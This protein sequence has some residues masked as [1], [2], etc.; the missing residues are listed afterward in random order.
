MVRM[1]TLAVSAAF[2]IA[3]SGN[4]NDPG[5]TTATG[6]VAETQMPESQLQAT[7]IVTRNVG[8]IR[9]DYKKYVLP[10]G[11]T[12]LLHEDRSDPLVHLNVTY[13][14]GS[15]REEPQRS[16]FAHFFEH[17]MFQGSANI[18]DDEHFRIVTESGGT[19]NGST[20]ADRT[21]YFQTV[22][23]NQL[24]TVLWL[25]ADRMG[26]LLEAVTQ[27]KFENQRATVKN[28]RGQNYD[29]RAYGLVYEKTLAALYPSGHPYSW[30]VIGYLD[31]LDSAT[32]DDLK[33]FFLRWYGPNNATLII[34]GDFEEQAALALLDKYFGSIP[35]GP[36]VERVVPEAVTLDNDR[37][38]SYVDRY[39]RFPMLSISFP[40]VPYSHP[41]RTALAALASII[42]NG[43]NSLFYKQFVVNNRAIAASASHSSLELAGSL[44]FDVQPYP[45]A[46]LAEFEQEIRGLLAAFNSDS[47]SDDDLETFKG[48][49]EAAL[50]NALSSVSGKAARLAMYDYLVDNPDYLPVEI[51]AIRRL[52]RDDILRVFNTYVAGKPAVL[53]SVLTQDKPDGLASP[54]NFTPQ[55][56]LAVTDS[57]LDELEPRPVSDVFDRSV[58]P[59]PGPAP[60][61]EV[62]PFWQLTL[63]NGA[64]LIGSQSSEIPSVTLQF[65]F[66]GGHLLNPVDKYGLAALTASMMNEGT[67]Q[68]SAEQYEIALQKLG[69]TLT[70][71]AGR[72]NMVVTLT[73]L[74]R[75]LPATLLLLE[76]RLLASDLNEESLG[77]LRRQQIES[78]QA[79]Q[80]QPNSIANNVYNTLLYG[81]DHAFAVSDEGTVESL[82]SITLA[83][84]QAFSR[85]AFASAALKIVAVGDVDQASLV[86]G[87]SFLDGLKREALSI[88]DVPS[89]APASETTLYLVDKP[90]AAQ[91]EIRI[92]YVTDMPYDATGEYYKGTLMNYVLGA[93]FTSRINLNLREDKGYTYGA[94][95]SFSSTSFAGPFTASS[96]VLKDSTDDSVRQFVNEIVGY[97][98]QGISNQ[99]LDFMRAAITQR[100]ALNYETPA[101]KAGFLS[102]MIKFDLP[103]D[104]TAQQTDIVKN[105]TQTEINSLASEKLP[106]ERMV[107][108]VVGDKE[109]IEAPLRA[110][111]YPMFELDVSGNPITQ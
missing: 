108:L 48:Q 85:D 90:G 109:V 92:G 32:L 64:E 111:G 24:E 102:R 36:A 26:F 69:S 31:D 14:V 60:E 43:K 56:A 89:A 106:F 7:E 95:S 50:I 73:S 8:D 53:M 82:E 51:D 87:L 49:S 93:A 45:G 66:E 35:P 34:A 38:I 80:Q 101:Q 104:V 12:V 100:E 18:G 42:G 79:A 86:S 39:I 81:K 91:S 19:L 96:S 88:V 57:A 107:I 16:G 9:I 55:S 47:I 52:T 33:H 63:A 6:M 97:R 110:L 2:L 23:G 72:E 67:Q 103:A 20:N 65:E 41:D 13:H 30:P 94:R 40:T 10:N 61:L 37:Y 11:L 1:I 28:E 68:L 4:D 5:D 25:E 77:R 27:E 17:M 59:A 22:P 15:A 74:S 54:D 21:N 105:I 83:D 44:R 58:Q 75:N 76:Q 62:P 98:E 78:L 46:E 99:E 71:S 29:N 84:V 70:V 3:C